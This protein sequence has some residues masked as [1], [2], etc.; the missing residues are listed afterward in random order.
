MWIETHILKMFGLQE[1]PLT[2]DISS[3]GTKGSKYKKVRTYQIKQLN[4]S[5]PKTRHQ[6]QPSH[7][8]ISLS[9]NRH[10]SSRGGRSNSLFFIKKSTCGFQ[11]VPGPH[12]HAPIWIRACPRLWL[13]WSGF[14]LF[15]VLTVSLKIVFEND[16]VLP[17]NQTEK[18][19]RNYPEKGLRNYPACKSLHIIVSVVRQTGPA[20]VRLVLYTFA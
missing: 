14:K 9:R 17:K 19:L 4:P 1:W 7:L 11:G 2:N 16:E 12:A 8:Q 3:P 13:Y 5:G 6:T 15:D 10:T 20:H 18:G